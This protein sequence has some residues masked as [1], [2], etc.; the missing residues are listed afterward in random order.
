MILGILDGVA[1]EEQ[2]IALHP[3]DVLILYTD[4]I[5]EAR[6]PQ[7]EQFGEDRLR[8]LLAEYSLLPPGA[9]AD[10]IYEAVRQH[11]QDTAQQD[12]I[13]LLILKVQ[14]ES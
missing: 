4:G 3:G 9:L 8:E 5:I 13:T 7:G 11:S 6:N 1:Y 10:R 2:S 12:D 14:G